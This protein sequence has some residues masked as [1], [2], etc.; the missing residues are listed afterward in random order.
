MKIGDIVY[1]VPA[2]HPHQNPFLSSVD[3][4]GKYHFSAGDFTFE[5]GA[6]CD[7]FVG[8]HSYAKAY[9]SKEVYEEG[10]ERR[11]AWRKLRYIM[12][13]GAMPPT[14]MSAA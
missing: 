1:I 12:S 4:S 2:S 9:T 13:L 10:L 7:E 5:R 14:H 11:D 3:Y 8:K 6:S